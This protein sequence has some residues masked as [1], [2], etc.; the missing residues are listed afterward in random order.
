M[1]LGDSSD[2]RPVKQRLRRSPLA[3]GGRREKHI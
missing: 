3:F 2:P 1:D